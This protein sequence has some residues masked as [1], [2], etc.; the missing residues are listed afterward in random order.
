[1]RPISSAVCPTQ[2]RWAIARIFSSDWIR[3][4][5]VTVRS[6]VLPPA[7]YVTDTYDGRSGCSS[8]I[9]RYNCA[10]AASFFGGKNSNEMAG[11]PR[12]KSSS[13]RMTDECMA[14]RRGTLLGEGG[15]RSG[16]G[17]VGG[18]GWGG[19]G[20]IG[21]QRAGPAP[22]RRAP[23]PPFSGWTEGPAVGARS[24]RRAG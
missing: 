14:P 15:G 18:G 22:A 5:S 13:I 3:S 24:K 4:T 1:M 20:V 11:F 17:G 9:V 12:P 7:P 2:V 8:P 23:R 16:G 6:R 10:N 21:G 19:G